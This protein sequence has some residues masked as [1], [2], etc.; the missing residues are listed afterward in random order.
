MAPKGSTRFTKETFLEHIRRIPGG[1]MISPLTK[2]DLA[3]LDQLIEEKS[4]KKIEIPGKLDRYEAVEG[5]KA[6][7]EGEK[8]VLASAV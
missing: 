7:S 5:Q 2:A 1:I 4:V 6:L 8:Y 3:L